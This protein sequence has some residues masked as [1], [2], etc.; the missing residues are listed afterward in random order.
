MRSKLN[1]FKE[2]EER[3]NVIQAGKPLFETIKGKWQDFFGNEHPIVFELG[4]G[5]GEYTIGLARKFPGI[6]YVGVDVKGARIWKGSSMAEEEKL[7][8][9]AFLRIRILEIEKYVQENELSEIWITFP[10]PRPKERDIKRR[11]TSERF[12]NIYKKL[13]RPNGKVH[14]KTDND[15]LF[16][17]TLDL[18][19]QRKDVEELEYSR[20]Y[21][22]SRYCEELPDIVT[23]YE[24]QFMKQGMKIKYLRF[25]FSA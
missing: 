9:V 3:S 2:N 12:M 8:N 14:F 23:K 17:F 11:L 15:P 6:N 18:L 20:D 7:D 25:I 24:A 4:C 19:E 21:H 10:D 1:R 13:L 22:A 5:R 16:D